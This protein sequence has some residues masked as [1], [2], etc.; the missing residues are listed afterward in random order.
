[1]STE[2]KTTKERVLKAA[3]KCSAAKEA[4]KE[5]FPEAF[6]AEP[7]EFGKEHE[8]GTRATPDDPLFIGGGLAPIGLAGK[9]LMV[10]SDY[11][12]EITESCG[13]KCLIFRKKS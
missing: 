8:I 1:M 6:Q 13:H 3:E 5:L 2:M 10:H 12:M 7:F 11:D 9:C 4:L